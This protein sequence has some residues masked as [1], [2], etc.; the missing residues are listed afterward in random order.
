ME[1]HLRIG[2]AADG[3]KVDLKKKLLKQNDISEDQYAE[4]GV[5]HKYLTNKL[6]VK[7]KVVNARVEHEAH[8]AEK[9]QEEPRNQLIDSQKSEEKRLVRA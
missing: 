5:Y 1:N 8:R 6:F 2:L 3:K 4:S 7:D 9:L